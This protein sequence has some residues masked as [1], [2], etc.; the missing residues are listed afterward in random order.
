[1]ALSPYRLSI[2]VAAR[3]MSI[4]GITLETLQE[5]RLGIAIFI[6]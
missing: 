5:S 1:M 4:S 3:Q 6:N 2:R